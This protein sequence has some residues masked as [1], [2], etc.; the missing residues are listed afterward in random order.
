MAVKRQRGDI[1]RDVI[2]AA[3][4]TA[5]RFR[6]SGGGAFVVVDP[7][8]DKLVAWYESLEFGSHR[9]HTTNVN[10]RLLFRKR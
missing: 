4:V 6:E 5:L 1:G 3:R 8:N 7:K 2:A 10:R 9:L